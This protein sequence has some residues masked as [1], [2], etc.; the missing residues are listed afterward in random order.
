[1]DRTPASQAGNTGST[2]VGI[3]KVLGRSQGANTFTPNGTVAQGLSAAL[4]SR[5][6]LVRV[7][8]VP[9]F[10]RRKSGLYLYL[11]M[12]LWYSSPKR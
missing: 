7:Q 2:P 1:M 12:V 3:T 5:V 6:M 9:P 11:M 10:A 8:P 4:E